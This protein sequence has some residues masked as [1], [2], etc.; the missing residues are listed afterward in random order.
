MPR[1]Q[2]I[3][4]QLKEAALLHFERGVPVG[5]CKV[6]A[7]LRKRLERV[8]HVYGLWRQHPFLDTY[9]LFRQLAR[10]HYAAASGETR[11]ARDDQQFFDYVVAS[12]NDN[13]K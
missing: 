9:K 4:P 5:D 7:Q 3:S 10:G 2:N 1:E 13:Q 12:M 6:H 11:A 8:S